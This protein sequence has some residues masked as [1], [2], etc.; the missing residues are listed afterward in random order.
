MKHT[1]LFNTDRIRML[2]YKDRRRLI[3]GRTMFAF[4]LLLFASTDYLIAQKVFDGGGTATGSGSSICGT[5]FK[6][7]QFEDLNNNGTFDDYEGQSNNS[8]YN[9]DS[10]IGKIQYTACPNKS[11]KEVVKVGIVDFDVAE[12][13]TLTIYEGCGTDGE[14]LDGFPF[15]KGNP[16]FNLPGTWFKASCDNDD[17]CLTIVFSPN[18]DIKGKGKGILFDISCE[19]R[20]IDITC[21]SDVNLPSICDLNNSDGVAALFVIP[22]P[23]DTCSYDP[24][25]MGNVTIDSAG[26]TIPTSRFTAKTLSTS[27]VNNFDFTDPNNNGSLEVGDTIYLLMGEY[28]FRYEY[29][30]IPAT[31]PLPFCEFE[32]EVDEIAPVCN[33]QINVSLNSGSCSKIILPDDLMEGDECNNGYTVNILEGPDKGSDILTYESVGRLLKVEVVTPFGNRCWGKVLVEDKAPPIFT[34]PDTALYCGINIHAN[35]A[36]LYPS[37][38]KDCTEF[39][40]EVV[41]RPAIS[42]GCGS[43]RMGMNNDPDTIGVTELAWTAIDT[44]GNRS[45]VCVQK[46]YQLKPKL[47]ASTII[48]P[49]DTVFYGCYDPSLISTGKTG[50]PSFKVNN[51]T[52]P[53]EYSCLFGIEPKVLDFTTDCDGVRKFGRMWTIIDW[54]GSGTGP[55]V[56]LSDTQYIK[57][58]DTIAP[59]LIGVPDTLLGYS[60]HGACS[61]HIIFPPITVVDDCQSATSYKVVGPFATIHHEV[62][63][64]E[65]DT[66]WNV[67]FGK[68]D[69]FYIGQDDCGNQTTKTISL[70]L[71]DTISPTAIADERSNVSLTNDSFTWVYATSFDN[72]STDNCW[73]D[74]ILARR[75]DEPDADSTEA[76][77][78]TCADLGDTIEVELYVIDE[79]GNIATVT[80]EVIIVDNNG[81][82]DCNLNTI[83]ELPEGIESP[84]CTDGPL[85]L[86]ATILSD[87]DGGAD[88]DPIDPNDAD[89]IT[90]EWG[91]GEDTRSISV[92][93]SGTYTVTI[94]SGEECGEA[95]IDVTINP[96][97]SIEPKS[98]NIP[99][100]EPNTEGVAIV[101]SDDILSLEAPDNFAHY[102]WRNSAGVINEG[103]DN[104]IDILT[105]N[106]TYVLTV[107]DDNGCTA[108]S[109][110][111]SIEVAIPDASFVVEETKGND[112]REDGIICSDFN[113]G[114]TLKLS[115]SDLTLFGYSWTK[116][117]EPI[118]NS[119]FLEDD[120]IEGDVFQLEVTNNLGCRNVSEELE[121]KIHPEFLVNINPGVLKISEDNEIIAEIS[122][123]DPLDSYEFLWSLSPEDPNFGNSTTNTITYRP[124]DPTEVTFMVTAFSLSNGCTESDDEIGKPTIP[125]PLMSTLSGKIQTEQGQVVEQTTISL[126]GYDMPPALTGATGNYEFTEVPMY[127]NY[128]VTPEKNMNPLNGVSTF[129]LV[130]MSKHILGVKELDSPYKLIAADINQSGTITAFDMVQLRKLI[131][132]ITDKFPNNTSWRFVDAAYDFQDP[133]NPFVE[134]IPETY[135]ITDLETDMTWLDFVAIKI[136]DLNGSV[137][138]NSLTPS[139]T[140]SKAG[141]LSFTTRQ[142][143]DKDE[144]TLIYHFSSENFTAINGYQ[145]TMEFDPSVLAFDR[146][147]A[148][149]WVGEEYFGLEYID[150]GVLM[151]SWNT[152]EAIDLS[153]EATIF[154][155]AFKVK[156][157]ITTD[158][159]LQINSNKLEAEAYQ[160]DGEVLEVTLKQELVVPEVATD[161]FELFQNRPN[162]FTGKTTI[163]FNLPEATTIAMRIFNTEGRIIKEYKGAYERG[164]NEL[165]I[166]SQD[167]TQYGALYYQ[168]ATP[169]QIATRKMIYT[170]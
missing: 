83:I 46:V 164:Y 25:I 5:F 1:S 72:G 61:A 151:S 27:L 39:T 145:F 113:G 34:C 24:V 119:A 58:L 126:T 136:G 169:T 159:L 77:G 22:A 131:L 78:F 59:E 111:V 86:T 17:G 53:I 26:V 60:E 134:A 110:A 81:V 93:E 160:A 75:L 79:C 92:T 167:L 63:S 44:F 150:E 143:L 152:G 89:G 140:R 43:E 85:A 82:C 23:T 56:I 31:S 155:L 32:V 84:L 64:T 55:S 97:V 170:K 104:I 87:D 41:P 94:T 108:E 20:E 16:K 158:D 168:L 123:G 137:Q 69:F 118:T 6:I 12:G 91:D 71:K 124:D 115:A 7:G 21:P 146:V 37:D 29:M 95:I 66:M 114:E 38:G 8:F 117:G 148:T 73:I 103:E 51:D 90:Y 99:D 10:T 14:I 28:T 18:G 40:Y 4:L 47:T 57:V 49:D 127:D 33:N 162:P 122:D 132:N 163:G 133:T 68:H 100:L 54:C 112:D 121:I 128:T 156:G 9:D 107:R 129:D 88:S 166:S 76:L 101:C 74:Q 2:L 153:Q 30:N 105:T 52:I 138:P 19:D 142:E 147:I 65:P 98:V 3:L 106:E 120:P 11:N 154:S 109:A 144:S 35:I 130:L 102:E 161:K 50:V 135:E 36:S 125:P 80:T 157:K 67:P 13:D 15:Y 70:E 165:I 62:G 139:T 116:N 48:W 42:F 149:D 141:T 45:N 96:S